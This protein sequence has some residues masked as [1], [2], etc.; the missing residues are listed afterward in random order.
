MKQLTELVVFMIAFS[1][2]MPA[3]IVFARP[4]GGN[5]VAGN[6]N[7]HHSGN[8]TTINQNSDRAIIN[9][10]SFDIGRNEAVRHNMPSASS[11]A[12]HRVVGGGGPSQIQGLL[13]SNGNI[14]LVNPAG[15]VIHNGARINTNSFTATSRD[16]SNS[17]FMKGNM[18]FDRPGRPDAQIIN[19]GN[20]TV[21]ESGL[22]AL[23]APTVRN[24]GV[25][26]G[27]LAKVALASGD[28][29]WKLDMHGD[30]L[31]TF[32]VDEKDVDTL[33]S[34]D[35][36]QLGVTNNGKIKAEGGI[37]VMTAAQLDGIVNSVVNTGEVSAASAEVA[38]G[39]ITFR[40]AG[41]IANTGV[42]DASSSKAKGGEIRMVAE[43]KATST[44]TIKA[45]GKTTGG[46]AVVTGKEVALKGKA[47]VDV[48]GDTG[49]GTALIGGNALG[50]GPE[51]N[52]KTTKVEKD[53]T[54]LA[55]AGKK[56]N[57]GE[58]VV[59]ADEKTTFAGSISAKG[60]SEGG[61]GG[62]VETSGKNL[63][64]EDGAKVNTSA[65]HGAYGQWLLDPMDFIIAASG[66]DMSGTTLSNS[67]SSTDMTI[68]STKGEIAGNGDIIV[69]D[70]INWDTDT[71]LTFYADHSVIINNNI[72]AS[73]D[74]S[75]LEINYNTGTFDIFNAK[76]TLSGQ[77]QK[78]IINRENYNIIKTIQELQNI[79]DNLGKN[80]A[81]GIDIDANETKNWNNGKGFIP[82]GDQGYSYDPYEKIY[83]Y[84]SFNG[85][86]HSI[87]NL[88]INRPDEGHVGLFSQLYHYNHNNIKTE[89]PSI[90][91][92]VLNNAYIK[93]GY[94]VGSI[95][96][97]TEFYIDE[98][99]DKPVIF[100][101]I[102]VIDS[103]VYGFSYVGGIVGS[104]ENCIVNK[105]LF[106]GNIYS[107][108]QWDIYHHRV[109]AIG[110]LVGG[111]YNSEINESASI[112]N[113]FINNSKDITAVG[114]FVGYYNS[115]YISNSFSL[116]NITTDENSDTSNAE[117]GGFIG[118]VDSLDEK[119][120]QNSYWSG[121]I[122]SNTSPYTGSFIGRISNQG[123]NTITISSCY[124]NDINNI[125]GNNHG[126][127][128]IEISSDRYNINNLNNSQIK[129]QSS[130]NGWDFNN[131]WI[132]QEGQTS[133]YLQNIKFVINPEYPNIPDDEQ[134][135]VTIP[136]FEEV[137][138]LYYDERKQSYYFIE[139]DK[140]YYVDYTPDL[141]KIGNTKVT[142][143]NNEIQTI[144]NITFYIN[145]K[146]N[147]LYDKLMDDS[148]KELGFTAA[149]I[150]VSNILSKL[151]PFNWI[152]NAGVG[153][154]GSFLSDLDHRKNVENSNSYRL[155]LGTNLLIESFIIYSNYYNE[156]AL[157]I[158]NNAKLNGMELTISEQNY[159][160]MYLDNAK[161]YLKMA[162]DIYNNKKDITSS[163]YNLYATNEH[164]N[165]FIGFTT[166]ST[167][168]AVAP[169]S[170]NLLDDIVSTT[171]GNA[172]EKVTSDTFS[173]NTK[174]LD[175]ETIYSLC[176]Y[177]IKSS[178]TYGL[179]LSSPLN[180]E[181]FNAFKNV[182]NQAL[183]G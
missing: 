8:N 12:L 148:W 151:N 38:G 121:A 154:A 110:G 138:T 132:I 37:V 53:V 164:F 76:I 103:D 78:L 51:K 73:G 99:Y 70:E 166:S 180:N 115:G 101:N 55:D 49:G 42:V 84:G 6:A 178:S 34:T 135:D 163:K 45:T 100:N 179:K 153:I 43:N 174:N 167:I 46:K 144:E 157:E 125:Y 156:K 20:I 35:G 91:N 11:A 116:L 162:E 127:G 69:N 114:G 30:E 149:R 111:I 50:K 95:A 146:C 36:K 62:K 171:I 129:L 10:N 165:D 177:G 112:G 97:G 64:I 143:D 13:Q 86:G 113:I 9:W 172:A 82:I 147:T 128:Y 94:D 150:E 59:W 159:L 48:S 93:G 161:M 106:S 54:L 67:L 89:I 176:T 119:I 90:K 65:E 98:N 16:I 72:T 44:G 182:Y 105:T 183:N 52:A 134:G 173:V 130:F 158:Y 14:Y 40:S 118:V 19:Q 92:L 160:N 104:L 61:D 39:K 152:K 7:I 81:L 85:L 170:Q 22:A 145:N 141:N 83:F 117:I 175:A 75:S 123:S 29:T 137:G 47:K 33:Y 23:V 142:L 26:A 169:N 56:G 108:S 66:G 4:Q 1:L 58:V 88:Y 102:N 18:V 24:E 27:K 5:V 25:I 181:V 3:H 96:G 136:D 133:P 17:N 131:I 2:V 32:T 155:V 122:S 41:D 74:N 87:N 79:N 60:G 15:V 140:K 57:G 28:S 68:K 77:N 21:K 107:S 109:E 31:I 120:L 63:K 126:I 139:D 124:F 168:E 71:T 80:Y